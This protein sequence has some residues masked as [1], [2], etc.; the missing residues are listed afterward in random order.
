MLALCRNRHEP[1][2]F[3]RTGRD[4][5]EAPVADR[6]ASTGGRR[7]LSHL[8][9]ER[10]SRLGTANRGRAARGGRGEGRYRGA[11]VGDAGGVLSGGPGSDGGGGDRGGAV[12][13]PAVRRPGGN[14]AELGCEGGVRREREG[15]AIAA[16]RGGRC[17][18]GCALDS[19]DRVAGGRRDAR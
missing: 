4:G 5:G 2:C 1:N 16:R 8:D 14:T 9:M 17:A 3:R 12:H 15:D 18:A 11:A 10:I 7:E 13:E 6:A 19:T